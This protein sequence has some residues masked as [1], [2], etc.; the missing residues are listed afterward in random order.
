MAEICGTAGRRFY[1]YARGTSF[2]E[3]KV[4]RIYGGSVAGQDD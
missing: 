4:C 3:R 2:A 1:Q